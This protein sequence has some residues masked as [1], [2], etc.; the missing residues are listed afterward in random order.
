MYK[1]L[2]LLSNLLIKQGHPNRTQT[3]DS[4]T[5]GFFKRAGSGLHR[6]EFKSKSCDCRRLLLLSGPQTPA[7][8]TSGIRPTSQ[9]LMWG[10][11]RME[12]RKASAP[13]VTCGKCSINKLPSSIG[14]EY[15]C[16]QGLSVLG[17]FILLF[18]PFCVFPLT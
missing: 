12:L 17:W 13:S 11:H 7:L 4:K 14:M 5:T 2:P 9:G 8:S 16:A 15:K 3:V 1:S 10:L 18:S 6:C